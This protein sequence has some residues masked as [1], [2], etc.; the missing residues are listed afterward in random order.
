MSE[1]QTILVLDDS[2]V[3]RNVMTQILRQSGYEVIAT[4]SPAKAMRCFSHHRVA[5]M[6]LDINMP[7]MRGDQLAVLFQR[8]PLVSQI[9]IVLVSD[10]PLSELQ[11][12][13]GAVDAAASITKKEVPRGLVSVLTS[14]IGAPA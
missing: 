5:A 11:E 3:A 2:E 8:H 9:P 6:I 10:R 13:Q 1:T 4:D 14:L 12:I 7:A